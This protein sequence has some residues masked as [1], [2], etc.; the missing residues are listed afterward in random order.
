MYIKTSFSKSRSDPKPRIRL[1]YLPE[2]T[3]VLVFIT[4][5]GFPSLLLRNK[6]WRSSG[7]MF[8]G[9]S[10]FFPRTGSYADR[11]FLLTTISAPDVP[12]KKRGTRMINRAMASKMKRTIVLDRHQN[13]FFPVEFVICKLIPLKVR[14]QT[15]ISRY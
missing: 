3:A 10:A 6:Y 8:R 13:S 11:V 1:W 7:P 9:Y 4:G 15:I 14:T 5:E 2:R 12:K